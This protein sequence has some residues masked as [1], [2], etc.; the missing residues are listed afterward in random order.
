[1]IEVEVKIRIADLDLL[2][3]KLKRQGGV[4]KLSLL[5]EDTYY[6]MPIGLRD[7]ANSDEA[8]RIRSS[9]EYDK[10]KQN[11]KKI[12]CY[13]TYK[14]KK[15]DRISK[16]RQEIELK[17]DDA[18]SMREILSI[19]GFREI[20]TVKKERELYEFEYK[21]NRIEALIDYLPAL[22]NYFLEVELTA[23]TSE[24][25]DEKRELLFDFLSL[26][27]YTK[28]DS[29]RKSYLELIIRKLMKSNK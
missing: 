29:I 26:F 27:G 21:D 18:K 28:E 25:L 19:I 23:H 20:L 16:S 4:Y 6:N 14:G 17:F 1:M 2:R 3:K 7:F 13:L 9:T 10:S 11:T 8:L 15:I 12:I 22:N 24:E 5:H